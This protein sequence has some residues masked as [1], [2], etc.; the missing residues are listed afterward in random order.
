MFDWPRLRSA[1][2]AQDSPTPFYIFREI[3]ADVQAH[4]QELPAI[5]DCLSSGLTSGHTHVKLKSLLVMKHIAGKVS[6]F[7]FILRSQCLQNLKSIQSQHP[8]IASVTGMEGAALIRKAADE[9]LLILSSDEAVLEQES[10]RIESRIQGYG[11]FTSGPL[12]IS[13]QGRATVM[14]DAGATLVLDTVKELATDLRDKGPVTTLKE[15]TL[16]VADMLTEGLEI[17]TGWMRQNLGNAQ[18]PVSETRPFSDNYRQQPGNQF[19]PIFAPAD[20]PDL[21]S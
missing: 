3:V 2:S 1:T 7:R 17:F 6:L 14:A 11:V 9:L 13:H 20:I 21:L 16:D 19:A 10:A 4:T 15:A 5:F 8:Q 18:T 12:Q